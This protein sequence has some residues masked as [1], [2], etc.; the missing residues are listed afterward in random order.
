MDENKRRISEFAI[1]SLVI[2]IASFISLA[3]LEKAILAIIF[4]ALALK[5]MQGENQ[6][7]NRKLANAGIILGIFS[8][9][10]TT[11][12]IVKFLPKFQEQIRQMQRQD[13]FMR[14]GGARDDYQ[15]QSPV[16]KPF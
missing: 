16:E 2:G 15:Q 1:A 11:I 10:A 4:G 6:L 13:N 12:F 8:I 9:I 5:R 14:G 3:G 7:L